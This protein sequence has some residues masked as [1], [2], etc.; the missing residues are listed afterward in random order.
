M[1]SV[2][3]SLGREGKPVTG[4]YASASIPEIPSYRLEGEPKNGNLPSTIV[5]KLS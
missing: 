2:I 5:R 4:T 3:G 1:I